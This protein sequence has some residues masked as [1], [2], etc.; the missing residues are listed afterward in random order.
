VTELQELLGD[1]FRL[2]FPAYVQGVWLLVA[3]VAL[4]LGVGMLTG[5]FGVGG[6]FLVSPM[7]VAVL[8]V[9]KALVVGSSLSFTIGTAGAGVA[10]HRRLGNVAP[11]TVLLLAA[12]ALVG[13]WL[14]K[15]ALDGLK[16]SLGEAGSDQAFLAL[17]LA[18]LL[19]TA[20]LVYRGPRE[21]A[22]GRSVLQRLPVGP[23]VT[24]RAAGLHGVSL[25]GLLAAGL[26]I[27]VAT[28]LLG[29]GGGVLYMPLLLL[30]VGLP[31]HQ[32][33]GTSL[34]VV[35]FSSVVGAL[36]YGAEG[37][38]N[39][40]LV[41][42]LLA[43]SSVGVQAGAWLCARLHARRLQRYFVVVVLLAALVVAVKLGLL[44]RGA[45]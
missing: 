32:A 29:I 4:G 17:Y 21:H 9:P 44:L 2:D 45:P 27:G 22:S 39:L 23:R 37:N 18:L 11:R 25:P 35:L 14:G 42:I 34:G 12:G 16:A 10:R 1:L 5:L 31:T 30:L 8:G 40:A 28:G 33:V 26:L 20:W 43:G 38:V 15:L 6:A 41:M 3:L 13:V 36:L 19:V 7:L 24:V